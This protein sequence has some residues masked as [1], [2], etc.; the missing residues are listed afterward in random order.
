MFLKYKGWLLAGLICL[1]C[2]TLA[3]QEAARADSIIV[4]YEKG[5]YQG[6]ELEF[7][8]SIAKN[9]EDPDL[10]LKYADLL[11][12]KAA[13]DS[14][15]DYLHRGYLHKGNAMQLKGS[16]ASSLNA[17]FSSLNYAHL[18]NNQRGIGRLNISI[19][20]TYSKSGN[21]QTSEDYYNRGIAVL[22]TVNDSI[23][24][25][26]ALLNAGEEYIRR[27]KFD[28]A[29][30]HIS[31]SGE[32]FEQ[33]N[34]PLGT[35]Y[36]LG[37]LGMIYAEQGRNELAK[38]HIYEAIDILEELEHYYPIAE[39]HTYMADIYAK[40]EDFPTAFDYA[41]RALDV[42]TKYGLKD[43]IG[44]ANL[45]LAD[46]SEAAGRFQNA[47]YYFKDYVTYRDSVKNLETIQQ[48]ANMRTDYE[49]SQK[50]VEVD[51]LAQQRQNQKI[52]MIS[53]IVALFLIA[54]LALGLYR[55]NKYIN[56]MSRVLAREKNRSD[57]LL[58]NILPE[59]TARELKDR[60]K[61]K[62]Q[63]FDSVTVMFA[64]F[65][66]FTYHSEYLE[67]E[68]LVESVDYY[69][70]KFDEVI[71]KYGLEKIKTVGDC[72]MCAGGLPFP[73]QDHT[74]KTLL[75]ALEI[76][77]FVKNAKE[78]QTNGE[79]RFEIRIGMNT[80]PVVAGVVGKKK[81]AYDI[82]GD[83]VNIA[84]RMETSSEAGRINISENTYQLVK[85]HFECE[86][87]GEVEV[88]GNK[89]MKMYYVT[90]L[91]E[92]ARKPKIERKPSIEPAKQGPEIFS[93]PA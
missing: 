22:R 36:T 38:R 85:H 9:Q 35:A 90:K 29:M 23:S 78:N 53:T 81:F 4:Q 67:P 6:N 41:E 16:Y 84:S 74:H 37:N 25:A 18:T 1:F 71:E 26:T 93:R 12:A 48:M 55:R 65:K 3:A 83:T 89:T 75:A 62:S 58:R 47:Y 64:D 30:E 20:D 11:I 92:F 15:Y 19:A 69:F 31:E 50:Q 34:Y 44:Q 40:Q 80:G 68:V 17:F 87:R 82:W 52:T 86:Y 21:A 14:I 46:L 7:L 32:I 2:L 39:Y 33:I 59:E 60:G 76:A 5:E 88:K 51:L 72:Y 66:D 24:L 42:A 91:K 63:R 27:G 61:V 10:L 56:K 8:D 73:S 28:E 57:H 79:V 13:E 77:D 45:T 70:T 54:L 49:V 43:E